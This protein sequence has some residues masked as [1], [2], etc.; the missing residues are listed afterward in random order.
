MF[1]YYNVGKFFLFPVKIVLSA[2][3]TNLFWTE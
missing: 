1:M 3:K 2:T